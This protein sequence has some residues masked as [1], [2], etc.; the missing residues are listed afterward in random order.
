MD[1]DDQYLKAVAGRRKVKE[2]ISPYM[3]ADGDIVGPKSYKGKMLKLYPKHDRKLS[4]V[5][6]DQD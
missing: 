3:D 5:L 2:P 1:P 4:A 6:A